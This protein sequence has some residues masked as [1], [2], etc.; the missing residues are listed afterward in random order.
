MFKKL[1]LFST[2]LT[3]CCSYQYKQ[4]CQGEEPQEST[5]KCPDGNLI[6]ISDC[7][8]YILPINESENKFDG[9]NLI[10]DED[11]IARDKYVKANL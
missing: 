7:Q 11:V 10:I 6:D 2:T 3:L 5:K 4:C 1:V 9:E 8:R